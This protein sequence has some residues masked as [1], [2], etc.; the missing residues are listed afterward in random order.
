MVHQRA[1]HGGQGVRQKADAVFVREAVKRDTAVLRPGTHFE[2][3]PR[4]QLL[5]AQGRIA[6]VGRAAALGVCVPSAGYFGCLLP[7]E[8]VNATREDPDDAEG[9]NVYM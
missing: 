8:Y 9:L 5:A 3:L 1:D 6:N 7:G 4:T 2:D